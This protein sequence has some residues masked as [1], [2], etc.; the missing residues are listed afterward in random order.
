MGWG[1]KNAAADGGTDGVNVDIGADV[2]GFIGRID[3]TD[4]TLDAEVTLDGAV[5]LA[6][7][8]MTGGVV[9]VAATAAAGAVTAGDSS[10]LLE[11]NLNAAP[12]GGR[13]EEAAAVSKDDEDNDDDSRDEDED[14]DEDVDADVVVLTTSAAD[15]DEED[16]G[17]NDEDDAGAADDGDAV[18]L[19][20]SCRS[21]PV[22]KG[23]WDTFSTC[24]SLF[25]IFFS[26]SFCVS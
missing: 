13:V 23:S 9:A 8:G 3:V 1:G 14:E 22:N 6:V 16:D 26:L 18:D 10:A 21:S 2:V 24:F 19:L 25:F 12:V 7:A 5:T 20:E 11:R 17:E 15:D 4:V